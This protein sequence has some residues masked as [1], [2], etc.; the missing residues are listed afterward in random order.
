ML[1]KLTET[2]KSNYI[3]LIK[4]IK[5]LNAR[6]YEIVFQKPLKA[7]R[8]NISSFGCDWS[9]KQ[10]QWQRRN[11]AVSAE[12]PSAFGIKQCIRIG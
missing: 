10:V 11:S 12:R 4:W 3:E 9:G 2:K 5:G 6:S 7:L 8:L 1:Y